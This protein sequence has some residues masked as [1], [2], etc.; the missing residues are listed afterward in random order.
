MKINWQ[1]YF[2][3]YDGYARQS[4]RMIRSLIRQGIEIT[5]VPVAMIDEFLSVPGWMR[6]LIP[7]PDFNNL[8]ISLL[9]GEKML[10]LP[11]RQW[12][13]TMYET[14]KVPKTWPKLIN[15]S[16]ERLFVP[17]K[18]NQEVFIKEGVKIP[19]D[20]IPLGIDP[21]EFPVVAPG[22]PNRPFTVLV[23]ADRGERKGIETA[24][25]AFFRAFPKEQYPDVQLLV[26]VRDTGQFPLKSTSFI[27]GRIRIWAEDAEHMA[28]VYPAGDVFLFPAY[29][30][31]WGL[32]PREAAAMGVPVIAPR[33]TGME[34]GI[35]SWATRVIETYSM[36]KA[37]MPSGGEWYVPSID[38]TAEHLRW[39]Y[40]HRDEARESGRQAAQ[41]L[42]D[43]QTWDHAASRL[44][45]ILRAS[46]G[47]L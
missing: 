20:I 30:E 29:G 36:Q 11:G 16:C 18:H 27:D 38:E 10:N 26:K 46:N 42:R 13:F 44:A 31:G 9:V 23:L 39:C 3:R 45:E 43:N 35:D 6:H 4:I 21:L 47:N 17:C 7:A 33:H 37:R 15:N 25:L 41:W 12:G 1:G 19:V 40:H 14:T 28:D 34:D 5:P 22:S 32:P 24:W 8:T 2:N